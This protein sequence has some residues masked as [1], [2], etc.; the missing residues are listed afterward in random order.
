MTNGKAMRSEEPIKS[1]VLPAKT[2]RFKPF[3]IALAI[4]GVFFV[5][6]PALRPFSDEAALQGAI[7]FASQEWVVSHV[8]AIFAFILVTFGFY[9]LYL[10]VQGTA[11]ERLA[12]KGLVFSYAGTGLT[13]PYYGAEIFGLRAIGQEAI[14]Q[15]SDALLNL[16]NHVR[17]GPGFVLIVTGLLLLAAG[18][19][20]IAIAVWK[21][22]M[23]PKW[24]G[25]PLAAG[26]LLFL[27]QYMAGQPLRI[28]HGLLLATGCFWIA[29][30]VWR[31]KQDRR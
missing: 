8:L 17:F 30:V 24:S 13:L 29:V 23:T 10:Y 19:A 12:R 11:G 2:R 14:R 28:V 25:L 15:N 3:A 7:A 31:Q 6:Y 21:S 22:R 26:F 27:P 16:A 4:A 9:G 1:I 20:M 18:S 5:L